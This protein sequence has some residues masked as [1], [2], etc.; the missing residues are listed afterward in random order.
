[1]ECR[2]TGNEN[3]SSRWSAYTAS[4][5]SVRS[6]FDASEKLC[7]GGSS[8]T[9]CELKKKMDEFCKQ[10]QADSEVEIRPVL[11]EGDVGL[12]IADYIEAHPT[13]VV[14]M[15]VN[16]NATDNNPGSHLGDIISKAC[17]PVMVVPNQLEKVNIA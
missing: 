11:L 13:D 12:K 17:V 6:R 14:L 2:P 15:G 3:G 5:I 9:I 10:L 7:A 4:C 16:S 8:E 1:M